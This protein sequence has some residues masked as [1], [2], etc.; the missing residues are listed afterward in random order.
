[1]GANVA[2]GA[3]TIAVRVGRLVDATV[4]VTVAISSTAVG[5]NIT[6]FL[7]SNLVPG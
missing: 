3:R 2:V 7:T 6:P 4:A 1:M 5:D